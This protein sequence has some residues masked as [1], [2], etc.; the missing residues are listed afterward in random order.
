MLTL[1][2][3]LACK[4]PELPDVDL[5]AQALDEARERAVHH[6]DAVHLDGTGVDAFIGRVNEIGIID[7]GGGPLTDAL[8]GTVARRRWMT[9]FNAQPVIG[10]GPGTGQ[11]RGATWIGAEE[12]DP[13]EPGSEQLWTLDVSSG[14]PPRI[15]VYRG[16]PR[17]GAPGRAF[18]LGGLEA[19][20]IAGDPEVSP[21]LA[22][23]VSARFTMR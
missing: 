1:A 2:L 5:R 10:K 19:L 17:P 14:S 22:R 8:L 3:L 11:S 21:S 6:G 23:A 7:A 16:D 4:L 13:P 20:A 18:A 9:A 12:V 15:S